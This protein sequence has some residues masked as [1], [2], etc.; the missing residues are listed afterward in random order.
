MLSNCCSWFRG[1]I[2]DL[3]LLGG[4]VFLIP[5]C[6]I[7]TP[8]VKWVSLISLDRENNYL[9]RIELSQPPVYQWIKEYYSWFFTDALNSGEA[10]KRLIEGSGEFQNKD[11]GNLKNKILFHSI[12]FASIHFN[13]F[14][15][16]Q[17]VWLKQWKLILITENLCFPILT[18]LR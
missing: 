7:F 16:P 15:C 10:C 17:G 6:T 12:N 1:A 14:D 2:W 9:T 13:G 8:R 5:L 18:L 11:F 4:S 3:A